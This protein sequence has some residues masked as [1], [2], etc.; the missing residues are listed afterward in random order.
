[1]GG[2]GTPLFYPPL[3]GGSKTPYF[4]GYTPK[5]QGLKR[6]QNL[7]KPRKIGQK[8]GKKGQKWA[9]LPILAIFWSISVML[10]GLFL[11]F[12]PKCQKTPNYR[13]FGGV[14][15]LGDPPSGG[16]LTPPWGGGRPPRR[17]GPLYI[18]QC[19]FWGF[20]RPPYG[21]NVISTRA[22]FAFLLLFN[23][24]GGSGG[25]LGGVWGG[26]RGW[27]PWGTQPP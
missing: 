10:F 16:G 4:W 14:P 15:P 9:Y 6:L 11:A 2:V 5:I 26:G 13:H 3:E 20:S 24:G 8:L 25:V 22:T 1:M 7:I 27:V 12:L 17:G 19:I 18:Y 23:F 21:P